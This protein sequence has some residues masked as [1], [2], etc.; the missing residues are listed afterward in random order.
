LSFQLYV[1]G[2]NLGALNLYGRQP[3]GFTDESEHIGLML[4]PTRRGRWWVRR[5]R[6]IYGS[7]RI[8]AT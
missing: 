4:A 6:T 7:R 1:E 3:N 2:D 8:V 5:S